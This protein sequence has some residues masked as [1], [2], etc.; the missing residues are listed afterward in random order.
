MTRTSLSASLLICLLAT[1]IPAV[2]ESPISRAGAVVSD[3]TDRTF[4]MALGAL[5]LLGIR[6]QRGGD[7]PEAGFDCSGFVRHVV[8]AS[9]GYVL[10]RSAREIANSP[11]VTE[12]DDPMPGDLVFFNTMRASFSHVGIY[13]GDNRFIHAPAA[14]GSVRVE[15]MQLPYWSQRFDGARRL[16]SFATH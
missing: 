12:A 6:Y 9:L 14:G 1:S 13:L 16:V 11:Q 4:D 3:V 2:A 8:K 15:N 10:P 5:A 7:S